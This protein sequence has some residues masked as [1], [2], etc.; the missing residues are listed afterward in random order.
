ML[1]IE[2]ESFNSG[3]ELL[4]SFPNS[5]YK[6]VFLD[7]YMDGISG[8]ETAF[9]IHELDKDCMIIFTTTSTDHRAEGFEV[10]AVHYLL[11]PLTYKGIEVALNRCKRLFLEN[12]KYIN[13]T[14]DRH[15]AK[16]CI[17]DVLYA[18]VYGKMVLI[19]TVRET[20][21]TYIPLAQ[22][23]TLFGSDTFLRCNR[24][25]LVN[26]QFISGVQESNFE[27]QGGELV[28]IRKNGRQKI[29]DQYT[30]YFLSSLRRSE[31]A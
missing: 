27:L 3:S 28:P 13:I 17:K 6:I 24:S 7:I 12:E 2:I 19:H 11:K 8:V 30:N 15:I 20:I 1:N 23:E 5:V 18:E 14:V 16:V 10:G 22:V 25:Y 26:M 31:D 4:S 21:K 9:K 29:K